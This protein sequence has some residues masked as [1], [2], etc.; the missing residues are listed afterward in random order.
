ML[1]TA[2]TLLKSIVYN[3]LN[4]IGNYSYKSREHLIDNERKMPGK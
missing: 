3:H 4:H 2:N 1:T